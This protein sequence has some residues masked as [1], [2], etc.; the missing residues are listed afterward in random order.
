M[1]V[2]RSLSHTQAPAP[3]SLSEDSSRNSWP[4]NKQTTQSRGRV[5]TKA[6]TGTWDMGACCRAT[7]ARRGGW[8][9]SPARG[10]LAPHK[11][12]KAARP[13]TASMRQPVRTWGRGTR[14]PICRRCIDA[15]RHCAT[16]SLGKTGPGGVLPTHS[17]L[18][19]FA[20]E[21]VSDTF[22]SLSCQ[23]YL[24][25]TATH[26]PLRTEVETSPGSRFCLGRLWGLNL[27][28]RQ[29]PPFYSR[30]LASSSLERSG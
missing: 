4:I 3:Q 23:C 14:R 19:F 8:V 29:E 5:K 30:G 9:R 27:L 26:H 10:G 21:A 25:C 7:L 6:F 1:C 13:E 11:C 28:G 22:F 15:T 18:R 16:V 2:T 12:R 20:P 17:G 24:K